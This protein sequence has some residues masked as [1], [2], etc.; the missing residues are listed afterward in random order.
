VVSE[1]SDPLQQTLSESFRSDLDS[2][3]LRTLFYADVFQF[4]MRIEEIH[5][6]LIGCAVPL[7]TVE[8]ALTQSAWLAE[9]IEMADGYVALR[10]RDY[11]I[12]QRA[13]R[14]AASAVLWAQAQRW[15]AV[16]ARLP[17]VRM[18][19]LT[20]ALA[21]RNAENLD[22]DLDFLI[23]TTPRRVWTARAA[24][25]LLVRLA[26]LFGVHLC[27][28]YVLAETAL[29]Q[30]RQDLYMAH[31][32]AQMIPLSGVV[33]YEAMRQANRWAAAYLPNAPARAEAESEQHPQGH[34]LQRM[35]ERV[36]GGAVGDALERWEQNRKI[37]K[38]A[39]Q[40][41]SARTAAQL[42][43]DHV[44]GHFNDYGQP[45]LERYQKRLKRYHLEDNGLPS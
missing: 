9:H 7:E 20:G 24:A 14:E 18:V 1:R 31:E 30:D 16:L 40:S 39:A 41:H 19:A 11:P 44:K 27:P 12:P 28:N 13:A 3:I 21:M 35:A 23:V 37:R 4:P 32:I 22:D 26:R 8:A 25:I 38:F 6:F 45:T 33:I 29:T 15:G 2:A 36:L 43:A 34:W 5:R 42:D 17:F 10:E